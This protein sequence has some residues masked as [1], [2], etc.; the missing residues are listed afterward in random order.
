MTLNHFFSSGL[1]TASLLLS[2]AQTAFLS[3]KLFSE[4]LIPTPVPAHIRIPEY[5]TAEHSRPPTPNFAD[6]PIRVD[7]TKIYDPSHDHDHSY[8]ILSEH[9]IANKDLLSNKRKETEL[10]RL[11]NP[12]LEFKF[13]VKVKFQGFNTHPVFHVAKIEN[14][15]LLP[16]LKLYT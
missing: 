3:G 16:F 6:Y 5:Y 11:Q 15:L 13:E 12:N 2:D 1:E 4:V 8:P 10:K 7:G 14:K 9:F